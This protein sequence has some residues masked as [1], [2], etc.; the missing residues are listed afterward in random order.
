M[1]SFNGTMKAAARFS[2][3]VFGPVL[4]AF[5]LLALC[6]LP[7]AVLF[8]LTAMFDPTV[9][10]SSAVPFYLWLIG[11]LLAALGLLLAGMLLY[12]LPLRGHSPSTFWLATWAILSI[13]LFLAAWVGVIEL[14]SIGASETPPHIFLR[15]TALIAA[16]LTLLAQALVI[17]WL[18]AVCSMLPGCKTKEGDECRE[19]QGRTELERDVKSSG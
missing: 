12:L 11:P 8:T 19:H 13:G 15:L 10:V 5:L 17:P 3:L 1:L 2:L 18:I 16:G 4:I 6:L 7:G 14:T 9:S